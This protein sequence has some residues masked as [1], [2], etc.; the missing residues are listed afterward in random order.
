M[1]DVPKLGATTEMAEDATAFT[2]RGAAHWLGAEA[3]WIERDQDA[4]HV[5][6]GR[7]AIAAIKPFARAGHY[8]NDVVESGADVV[9]GIYG[10]AKYERLVV[11]KR[12]WDPE[13]SMPPAG[14][15]QKP[16]PEEIARIRQ[17]IAAGCPR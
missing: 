13:K 15:G 8:V 16:K 9:R 5:A 17:W 10:D 1:L 4:D 12:E 11:L 7:A 3:F 14:K 2:G 6:W